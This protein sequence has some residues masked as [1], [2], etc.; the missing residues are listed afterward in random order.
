MKTGDILLF[1]GGDDLNDR[2]IDTMKNRGSHTQ[3]LQ[4]MKLK[5]SMHGGMV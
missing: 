3:R 5:S 1:F 4:S 2:E